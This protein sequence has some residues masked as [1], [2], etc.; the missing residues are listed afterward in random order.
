MLSRQEH[1]ITD[2]NFLNRLFPTALGSSP[3][4]KTHNFTNQVESDNYEIETIDNN[5]V[6]MTA[7]GRGIKRGDYIILNK[8]V[9]YRVEA[10]DYYSNPMNLWTALLFKV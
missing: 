8:K 9:R 7:Y 6:Q 1:K 5:R 4:A 3:K 2:L 10:I